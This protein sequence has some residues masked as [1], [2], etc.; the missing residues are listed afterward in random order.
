MPGIFAVAGACS[1]THH[2]TTLTVGTD[3][4]GVFGANAI[5]TPYGSIADNTLTGRNG[6]TLGIA[7]WTY[8]AGSGGSV[9]FVVGGAG[10]PQ[11]AILRIIVNGTSLRMPDATYNANVGGNTAWTWTG[12]GANPF[13][14]SGT[15]DVEIFT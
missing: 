5:G 9:G 3:G 12:V 7:A 1:G 2:A 6:A 11:W 13:G 8:A 4:A 14:E 15:I 10:V